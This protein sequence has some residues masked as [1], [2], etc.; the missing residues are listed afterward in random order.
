VKYDPHIVIERALT[1][2]KSLNLRE[3]GNCVAFRVAQNADKI[4][5]KRAV[6]ELFKVKV[7][8]VRTMVMR[9]KTKR[10][11]RFE[12]QRP[13]WKKALVTL[14]DGDHIELFEKV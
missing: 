9:G 5:I 4:Q 11:G 6:E 8:G 12:G 10:L 13:S 3:R 1:T 2:E 7:V 14:R